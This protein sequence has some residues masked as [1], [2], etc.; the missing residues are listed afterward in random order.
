MNSKIKKISANWFRGFSD[1]RHIELS[2]K[3]LVVYGENGSGKSSFV[4]IVE[5]IIRGGQ[6]EHLRHEYSGRRQEKGI[7]NTH[8]P[9]DQSSAVQIDFVSGSVIGAKILSNGNCTITPE[10]NDLSV[11]E[12]QRV[13]LRQDEVA[14]FIKETK[15][16]KYSSLLPLL[17]LGNLDTAIENLKKIEK[18]VIDQTSLEYK[19][20]EIREVQDLAKEKFGVGEA[21]KEAIF[22]ELEILFKKYCPLE[23]FSYS[24]EKER[25]T[26]LILEALSEKFEKYKKEQEIYSD[27]LS[28]S[29]LDV[30]HRISEV[31]TSFIKLAKSTEPLIT[32]R[33]EVLE[34]ASTYTSKIGEDGEVE[35]PACGTKVFSQ[36]F[37][38]HVKDEY[39]RLKDTLDDFKVYKK[40]TDNLCGDLQ[41][42]KNLF[43]KV[44]TKQWRDAQD[45]VRVGYVGSLDIAQLRSNCSEEDL[46]GIELNIIPL[47]GSATNAIKIVPPEVKELVKDNECV[48]VIKKFVEAKKINEFI[49]KIEGLIAFIRELQIVIRAKIKTQSSTAISA[50]SDDIARMWEILNPEESIEGVQ[51]SLPADQDKAIEIGLKFYGV[52]QMSPR[53]TLSEGHRN[54]LGLCIFLAMAKNVDNKNIPIILDDIVVSFDRNHRGRV[55][56]LLERELKDR[57]ILLFTH[58]RE[59]FIE[60][61][62]KLDLDQ[63]ELRALMPW[64][65][66]STGIRW[67]NKDTNF[68]DAKAYLENN[69]PAACNEARKIMDTWLPLFAEK[70]RLKMPYLFREKN[71]NRVAHD[72]LQRILS[73]GK[74]CF[75][76]KSGEN[77]A[78]YEEGLKKIK[79]VD[80]E[81]I[82]IANRASHT[83]SATKTEAIDLI[84]KCE[85]AL[86]VFNCKNCGK[87]V[88]QKE[89]TNGEQVQCECGQLKWIYGKA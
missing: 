18:D 43:T 53:L 67:S 9:T 28:L 71:D 24:D 56:E 70:M 27:L 69:P 61:K 40:S 78:I 75:V 59:W 68:D 63:W 42:L 3:S 38:Q 79:E 16:E 12:S 52:E 49:I 47:I 26:H 17:G 86:E 89:D 37:R 85:V 50:I 20:G 8:K 58:D 35:C 57:Q 30:L 31:R 4:D 11:L 73:D 80:Q 1:V 45:S 83:Y 81:L 44:A 32:E 46:N 19:R 21:G 66:P 60:L 15:G 88:T 87:L 65:D 2:D 55:A 39:A 14:D 77:V 72:F 6:L 84:N 64:K 33:L 74:K 22:T 10:Q 29:K 36:Y 62:H 7:I 51:L 34:K 82:A 54:S 5:Y 13:I 41:I 25:A 48:E 23:T 76:I